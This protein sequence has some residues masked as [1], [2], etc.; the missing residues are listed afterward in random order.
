MVH[1]HERKEHIVEMTVGLNKFSNL[2]SV[3]VRNA[4]FP[5]KFRLIVIDN[6]IAYASLFQIKK[7]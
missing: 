1:V 5:K 2:L 3:L 7:Y 6:I 4:L